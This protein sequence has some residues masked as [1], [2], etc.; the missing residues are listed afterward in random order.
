M[1]NSGDISFL[2]MLVRVIHGGGVGSGSWESSAE[3][4]RFQAAWFGVLLRHSV[5]VLCGVVY[6]SFPPRTTVGVAVAVVL[7][8]WG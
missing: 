5:N 3:R 2:P 8:G 4:S 7:I 1:I 6:L